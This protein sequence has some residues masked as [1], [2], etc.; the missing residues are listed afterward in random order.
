M[1][2]RS[3]TKRG[4]G[5]TPS[6]VPS[7]CREVSGR[8]GAVWP[9]G[10]ASGPT[11]TGALHRGGRCGAGPNSTAALTDTAAHRSVPSYSAGHAQAQPA[12]ARPPRY[13][14]PIRRRLARN[15]SGPPRRH[16]SVLLTRDHDVVSSR[17]G[18][19]A[20][21]RAQP[22]AAEEAVGPIR[23][24]PRSGICP[25]PRE[26]IKGAGGTGRTTLSASCQ[27]HLIQLPAFGDDPGAAGCVR[28]RR[29][30]GPVWCRRAGPAHSARNEPPR[31]EPVVAQAERALRAGHGQPIP[32][33]GPR[34]PSVLARLDDHV[35]RRERGVAERTVRQLPHRAGLREA[36]PPC[37]TVQ[38]STGVLHRART[39]PPGRS[40]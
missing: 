11:T 23:Y 20:E 30:P 17:S 16:R 18:V 2:V 7:A 12:P 22:T 13:R 5:P 10:D 40:A 38:P 29:R 4:R 25:T 36:R 39:R 8:V 33:P 31:P 6:R 32:G 26:L 24:G 15:R 37:R 9:D 14:P 35:R 34:M 28:R 27:P 1:S 21:G 19:P 3:R